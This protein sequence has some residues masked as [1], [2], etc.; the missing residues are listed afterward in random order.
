MKLYAEHIVGLTAQEMCNPAAPES[1]A[2]V[3]SRYQA[4]LDGGVLRPHVGERAVGADGATFPLD[5][6]AGDGRY[7]FLSYGPRYRKH[8]PALLCYGFVFDADR[9][10]DECGALVGEDLLASYECILEAAVEEVCAGLPPLPAISAEEL[11]AF[12]A[13]IG[14]ND[15]ALL[16]FVQE[17]S[18]SRR[19]DIDMAVR[20]G[21]ESVLG[22]K[23]A[24]SLFRTRAAEEQR[25]KRVV[26]AAAHAA[27]RRGMEV[28]VCA[29]LPL[30]LAV[31]RIE[32]GEMV[33]P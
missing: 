14:G 22:M 23:E 30:S 20:M 31:G 27:L 12:A 28:L 2:S 3:R 17:Q 26:G 10:I 6:L 24:L 5:H 29:G 33:R 9:L 16:A 11:A 1:A 7:V 13:L 15:P 19:H 32:A 21:D 18:T 25:R 4:I 8:R